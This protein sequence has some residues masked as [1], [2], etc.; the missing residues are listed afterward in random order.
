MPVFSVGTHVDHI[1]VL[2]L[3]LRYENVGQCSQLT[4]SGCEDRMPD[5]VRAHLLIR[6]QA[7]LCLS[8]H[9]CLQQ[10]LVCARLFLDQIPHLSHDVVFYDR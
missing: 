2:S 7:A 1:Q 5:G 3:V 8:L 4:T 6:D 9:S 10:S